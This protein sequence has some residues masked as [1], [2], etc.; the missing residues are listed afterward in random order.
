M[1]ADRRP[2]Y[3]EFPRYP[4]LQAHVCSDRVVFGKG[5]TIFPLQRG[6]RAMPPYV[7]RCTVDARQLVYKYLENCSFDSEMVPQQ[8]RKSKPISE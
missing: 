5:P 7:A 1:S 6:E 3:S 2:T 4:R 8:M